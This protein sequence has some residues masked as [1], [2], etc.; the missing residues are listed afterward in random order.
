MRRAWLVALLLVLGL[1]SAACEAI[2]DIFQA[3]M[4]VGIIIV[5]LIVAGIG[6]LLSRL[7]R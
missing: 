2:V 3:G 4:V 6:Y 5:V 1:T 7:R